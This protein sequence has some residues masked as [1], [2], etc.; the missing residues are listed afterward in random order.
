[1]ETVT[2]ARS[3]LAPPLVFVNKTL[4]KHN[5]ACGLKGSNSPMGME[6]ES[7]DRCQGNGL[8]EKRIGFSEGLDMEE[9][10]IAGNF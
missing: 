4:L 6:E 9:R 10:G 8:E 1:M 5:C 3:H 2:P 7:N